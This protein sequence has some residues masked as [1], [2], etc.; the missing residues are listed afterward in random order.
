MIGRAAARFPLGGR[1]GAWWGVAFVILLLVSA[2][3]VS[4]PTA[5]EPGDRIAAFYSAHHQ[6]IVWQQIVAPSR[7]SRFWPSPQPCRVGLGWTAGGI[8]G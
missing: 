2:A 4:L 7:S 3:M 8:D 5:A 6:V 1:K